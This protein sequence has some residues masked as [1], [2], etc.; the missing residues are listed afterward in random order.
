M[1]TR[2]KLLTPKEVMAELRIGAATGDTFTQPLPN[3]A[4]R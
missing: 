2:A 1:M 4:R 3:S